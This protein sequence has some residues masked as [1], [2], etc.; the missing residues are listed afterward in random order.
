MMNRLLAF[1][2]SNPDL[3]WALVFALLFVC[4][5]V[6]AF[7]VFVVLQRNEE[8]RADRQR[9]RKRELD[10]ALALTHDLA[11]RGPSGFK[12]SA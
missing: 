7:V 1:F 6:I 3:A 4:A 9:T 10:A 2:G 11:K 8:R 5:G 12:R